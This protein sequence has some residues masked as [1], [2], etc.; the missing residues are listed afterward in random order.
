MENNL[1]QLSVFIEI[2]DGNQDDLDLSIRQLRKEILELDVESVEI[3]FTKELPV[4]VKSNDP[5]SLG[6]LIIAFAA[7]Q[8]VFSSLINLLTMWVTRQERKKLLIQFGENKI[9]LQGIPEEE[10][11]ELLRLW[12]E[13]KMK[14]PTSRDGKRYALIIGNFEYED[15]NLNQLISPGKDAEGLSEVLKD[16]DVGMFID[17]KTLI[18]Q[19]ADL[20]R[21]STANFF[22]KK[23]KDDLLLLY[24][25]GHGILDDLGHL[26][27]ATVD[28]DHES[29]LL[30]ATAL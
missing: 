25:S 16:P 28:T 10:Q 29:H 12:F 22:A 26:Y 6:T 7:S 1:R 9:E 23:K 3:P 8:G 2:E 11:K 18:N 24:F 20:I 17:V 30:E 13:E 19:P 15:T 5:I 4:G 27:L 14:E 21:K